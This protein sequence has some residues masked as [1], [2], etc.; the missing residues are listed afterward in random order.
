[1]ASVTV[2]H[3]QRDG[4]CAVAVKLTWSRGGLG[5][6]ATRHLADV[7]QPLEAVGRFPFALVIPWKRA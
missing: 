1:M 2:R 6:L 7:A 5:V 4:V 3:L